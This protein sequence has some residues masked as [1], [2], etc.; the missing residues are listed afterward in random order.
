MDSKILIN[1]HA[2]V[3]LTLNVGKLCGG[4]H[5]IDSIATSVDLADAVFMQKRKDGKITINISGQGLDNLPQE[6]NNAHKAALLFMQTFKCGGAQIEIKKNIPIGAGLGGSAADAAAVLNGM[7]KLYEIKDTAAVYNLS[8]KISSDTPF[9][10]LGGF[11]LIQGTGDMVRQIESNLKLYFLCLI[12]KGGVST[13]ECFDAFDK[14]PNSQASD[15]AAVENALKKGNFTTLCAN[16]GNMLTESA[17]RLNSGILNAFERLK[18][19]DAPFVNMSGSGSAVYALYDNIEAAK[20]A[21][22]RCGND[23]LSFVF[24]NV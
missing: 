11:G 20:K 4:R 24:A 7:A 5:I 9:M 13:K 1:A 16:L 14:Q 18:S 2:K 17:T 23:F 3:N 12:A 21:Q 6:Q 15:N 22:K 10:T 19:I 8:K